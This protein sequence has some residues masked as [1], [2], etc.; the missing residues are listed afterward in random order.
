MDN[1]KNITIG[2][3]KVHL[4]VFADADELYFGGL[5]F[6]RTKLRGP[7]L[8]QVEFSQTVYQDGHG[9]VVVENHPKD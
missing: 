9:N 1:N 8:V 6:Y 5:E 7:G 4:A 3:L 2:E